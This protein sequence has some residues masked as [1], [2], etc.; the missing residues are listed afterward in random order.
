MGRLA[1]ADRRLLVAVPP[2]PFPARAGEV[3][4]GVV[5]ED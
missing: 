2:W 3:S 1:H 4:A 5:W